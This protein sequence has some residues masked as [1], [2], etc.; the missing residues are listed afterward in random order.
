MEGYAVLGSLQSEHIYIYIY[1]YIY[2]HLFKGKAALLQARFLF[3]FLP[4]SCLGN[5][6]SDRLE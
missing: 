6:M 3:C 1:I 5:N 4:L 2:I